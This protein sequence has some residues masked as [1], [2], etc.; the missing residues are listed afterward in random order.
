MREAI[1]RERRVEFTFEGIHLF[2]TRSW[3][4][5]EACVNKPAY[6][7][8]FDGKKVLVEQRKFDPEKNYLWAIPLT[9]IDL[10]KGALVQNPGY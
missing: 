4:T 5:T 6:G 7:M 3:R 2:E 1:R 10:S 9:E 8:T